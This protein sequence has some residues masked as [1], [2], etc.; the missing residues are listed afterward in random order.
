MWDISESEEYSS[1][2]TYCLRVINISRFVHVGFLSLK[3]DLSFFQECLTKPRSSV[4]VIVVG[5]GHGKHC[6]IRESFSVAMRQK[7][8][9]LYSWQ[10]LLDWA[11]LLE[12]FFHTILAG[13]ALTA[14]SAALSSGFFRLGSLSTWSSV[15]PLRGLTGFPWMYSTCLQALAIQEHLVLRQIFWLLTYL[16]WALRSTLFI[17]WTAARSNCLASP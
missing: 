15:V 6:P 9:G 3:D 17:W 2:I 8:R 4:S 1:I 5:V 13:H 14:L 10:D 12:W 16:H 7:L 11:P